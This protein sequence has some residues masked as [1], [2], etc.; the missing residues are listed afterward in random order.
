[1]QLAFQQSGAAFHPI[2]DEVVNAAY[3]RPIGV[4]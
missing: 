2:A 1:M 4:P 3:H